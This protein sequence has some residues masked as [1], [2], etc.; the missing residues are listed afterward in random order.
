MENNKRGYVKNLVM[1]MASVFKQ[2]EDMARGRYK[3][4]VM[5]K[6]PRPCAPH[7]YSQDHNGIWMCNC[8]QILPKKRA[9]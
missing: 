6:G 5:A 8:G 1:S 4:G 2:D 7:V 9:L 3:I